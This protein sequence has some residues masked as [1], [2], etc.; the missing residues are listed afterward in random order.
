MLVVTDG[1]LS[2][3]EVFLN[4]GLLYSAGDAVETF[5]CLKGKQLLADLLHLFLFCFL[6]L[7]DRKSLFSALARNVELCWR[8]TQH[9]VLLF[10]LFRL[11][12]DLSSAEPK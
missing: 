7:S 2:S 11:D 8:A 6:Q 1:H 3:S 5:W 9:M 4:S 10:S 12:K